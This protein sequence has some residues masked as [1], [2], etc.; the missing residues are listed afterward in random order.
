MMLSAAH[1]YCVGLLTPAKAS[2][3]GC[4]LAYHVGALET[5]KYATG[6]SQQVRC[7]SWPAT[8]TAAL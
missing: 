7:Q 8:A 6:P 1:G 4:F 3:A 5:S 2:L